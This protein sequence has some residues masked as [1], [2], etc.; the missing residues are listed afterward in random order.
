MNNADKRRAFYQRGAEAFVLAFPDAP[1]GYACP[2]CVA[3]LTRVRLFPP[4]AADRGDVL[5]LEHVPP[6]TLGGG[7]I[8]LTCKPCN[9]TAGTQLVAET[10]KRRETE[11]F[12][13][14]F[15]EEGV[16]TEPVEAEIKLGQHV[17]RGT[18]EHDA[19]TIRIIGISGKN[20]PAEVATYIAEFNRLTQEGHWQEVTFTIRLDFSYNR[21]LDMVSA[22]R[23]SYLVA[24]AALGY[25]YIFNSRLEIVHRQ[26]A[27]PQA[28]VFP[29]STCCFRDPSRKHSSRQLLVL[30]E[31]FDA[32]LVLI[33]QSASTYR[34]WAT[35]RT[36]QPI[37]Q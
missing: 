29:D 36:R 3:D 31:P 34:G 14:G 22:L 13:R 23:D 7:P 9:N 16:T 6:K 4:G 37:S 1:F 2:T 5:T 20:N 33:G 18:V 26:L 15:A 25:S 28:K 12:L 11:E 24:F 10:K 21:H 8:A 35:A 19:G 30:R 17:L 32:L 27:D